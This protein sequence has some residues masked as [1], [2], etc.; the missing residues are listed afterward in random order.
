MKTLVYLI[1][2]SAS[3]LDSLNTYLP[4]LYLP[5]D[6][7]LL[8]VL[9]G[10]EKTLNDFDSL[11]FVISHS[12]R[13]FLNE[14]ICS[15]LTLY[16]YDNYMRLDPDD[17]KLNLDF[18]RGYTLSS[19]LVIPSYLLLDD[20][21]SYSLN[22]ENGLFHRFEILAAGVLIPHKVLSMLKPYLIHCKGQDNFA[23]WLLSLNTSCTITFDSSVYSYYL[24]NSSS[25]SRQLSR[26]LDDRYKLIELFASNYSPLVYIATI[27]GAVLLKWG[28]YS[29]SSGALAL[30]IG[31]LVI[32]L[33]LRA[34]LSVSPAPIFARFTVHIP[35]SVSSLKLSRLFSFISFGSIAKT[36][37][38]FPYKFDRTFESYLDRNCSIAGSRQWRGKIIGH[39]LC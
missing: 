37:H 31:N 36:R 12:K 17:L 3:E 27:K 11:S 23:L 9:N 10:I 19:S 16:T 25:M 6:V 33:R 21:R 34:L 1:A 22:F 4:S 39:D 26:I 32:C 20:N 28:I 30:A 18:L 8:V 29:L 24:S 2:S 14:V 7:Q 15:M 35:S 13:L 38:I 5:K